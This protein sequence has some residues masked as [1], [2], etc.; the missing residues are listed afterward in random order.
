MA[1][2]Q[3]PCR[4]AQ[5]GRRGARWAAPVALRVRIPAAHRRAVAARD[6]AGRRRQP[7]DAAIAKPEPW[8]TKNQ[9]PA[10]SEHTMVKEK[11][12]QREGKKAP[13]SSKKEKKAAKAAKRASK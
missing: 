8:R 13:A 11:Q 6:A 1:A 9:Q 10:E 7:N 5:G 2:F 12:T 4:A 3:C